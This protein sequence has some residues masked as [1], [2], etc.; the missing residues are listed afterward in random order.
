MKP[1]L[2]IKIEKGIPIPTTS[3]NSLTAALRALGVGDS[4]V[5]PRYF[6]THLST[7]ARKAGIA[8]SSRKI[9]ETEIRVWRTA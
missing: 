4:A 3:P 1:T 9:S 2:K 6:Q 5:L 7:T 8:A